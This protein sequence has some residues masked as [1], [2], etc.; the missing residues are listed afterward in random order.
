MTAGIKANVDGSGAI[1]VGGTDVIGLA[2]NGDVGI[3]T[4][5][6]TGFGSPNL[7][8]NGT[9]PLVR[10]TTPTSGTASGDGTQIGQ[11]G[12][13]FD[14]VNFEAGR[15]GLWT[16]GGQRVTIDS[17]G[18]VGIG[19]SSPTSYSATSKTL[20]V[21][22]ANTGYGT[23][24]VDSNGTALGQ[25]YATT[26]GSPF[27][28]VGSRSNHPFL[29]SV[30]NTERMRIDSSGNV[31]I[32]L[33]PAGTGF[34]EIKAGTT[35]A[36]PLE[37]NAG[38]NAS[39]AV[40]GG[41]E[42]DGRV[43]YATP[44]GTQRGVIPGAQF[45]RLN[46][47]LVGANVNTAQNTFGVGVTLSASTVYAFEALVIVSKSAGTTSHNYALNFG[48]TATL[49]NIFWQSIGGYILSATPSGSLTLGGGGMSNAASAVTVQGS[50]GSA[51][52][53]IVT[54]IRGTVSINAGGTFIPQYTLSAAP[55]GAYTTVAG[56][57]FLIYPIGAAGANT[58]VGTWA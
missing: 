36:V 14:I 56:S 16:S 47:G 24:L 2:T 7:Q 57:Y 20:H 39:T 38:T 55:G 1:Q 42:Y 29:F 15:I 53:S 32:G 4:T 41:V 52:I 28:M 54:A 43:F 27:V 3:G 58:S 37:L 9:N 5:S 35:S 33:V 26:D 34:L 31:G 48:G 13:D 25:F 8:V 23:V 44:Q 12:L 50:I 49:N 19:T 6:P 21:A 46:S 40:A 17:S 18:N 10:F 51:A 45:F 11:G 22:A 30:N